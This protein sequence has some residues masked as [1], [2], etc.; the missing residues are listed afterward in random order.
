[1]KLGALGNKQHSRLNLYLNKWQVRLN[2]Q[3]LVRGQLLLV[4][5][6]LKHTIT[7]LIIAVAGLGKL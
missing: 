7:L 3:V 2:R 6:D 4:D 1:M 5:E